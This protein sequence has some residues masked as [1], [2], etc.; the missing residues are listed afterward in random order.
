MTSAWKLMKEITQEKITA[1]V[2]MKDCCTPYPKLKASKKATVAAVTK[3]WKSQNF[4]GA[5]KADIKVDDILKEILK[6]MENGDQEAR[7]VQL[8]NTAINKMNH[9]ELKSRLKMFQDEV[10][11]KNFAWKDDHA[12]L[13]KEV[14]DRIK[15][16]LQDTKLSA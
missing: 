6:T 2:D 16:L 8:M 5:E 4:A 14:E 3:L 11:Q 9:G 15:I 13:C 1:M 12:K 7:K 10:G